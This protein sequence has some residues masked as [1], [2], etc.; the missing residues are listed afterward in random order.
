MDL[1]PNSRM[2]AVAPHLRDEMVVDGLDPV[3]AHDFLDDAHVL[4]HHL[5]DELRLIFPSGR[6]RN[7][8]HGTFLH[9]G[10][11]DR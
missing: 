2:I 6:H 1:T 11:D 10:V 9:C 7:A 5:V 4:Q 8:G 3:V